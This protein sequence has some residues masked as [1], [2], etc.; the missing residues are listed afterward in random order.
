MGLWRGLKPIEVKRRV[1]G[2]DKEGF[3]FRCMMSV[4]WSKFTK[5]LVAM[6]IS[7]QGDMQALGQERMS[8]L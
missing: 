7:A 1:P 4:Q 5:L 8:V 2:L 3:I 6:Q